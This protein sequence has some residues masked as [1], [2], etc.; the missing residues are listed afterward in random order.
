MAYLEREDG[1]HVYYED[2]GSGNSAV[3]LSHGWGMGVRVWDYTLGALTAAGHRVIL[4]D[5]RGCGLSDKDFADQGIDANADPAAP[6]VY[7]DGAKVAALGLR[8]SRGRSFHG[9]GSGSGLWRSP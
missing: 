4:V 3:I 8:V 5:H 9:R 6:G 7:V 2:Y 1:K